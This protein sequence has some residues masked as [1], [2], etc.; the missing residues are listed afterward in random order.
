MHTQTIQITGLLPET[1][2]TL[3]EKAQEAGTTPEDFARSLIEQG[4]Y[5]QEKSFEEILAPFRRQVAGR[6]IGT[7]WWHGVGAAGG[8]SR[9]NFLDSSPSPPSWH[10]HSG[11]SSWR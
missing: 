2:Q 5:L 9:V 10:S 11:H 6:S 8:K 3:S 7:G 1:V 4:L